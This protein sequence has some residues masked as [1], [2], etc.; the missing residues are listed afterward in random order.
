[1][2]YFRSDLC[3]P[4]VRLG[5]ED[6]P[7]ELCR[8]GAILDM[9]KGAFIVRFRSDETSEPPAIAGLRRLF[10]GPQIKNRPSL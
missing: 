5:V 3:S 7:A 1:M 9:P 6:L 4:G 10:G 8:M 2:P